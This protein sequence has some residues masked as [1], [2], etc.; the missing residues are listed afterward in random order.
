MA[1]R[2]DEIWVELD[3]K[4]NEARESRR[5]KRAGERAT[6]LATGKTG[7]HE[8]LSI[9][10]PGGWDNAGMPPERRGRLAYRRFG[11]WQGRPSG[12]TCGIDPNAIDP[13][14]A[15]GTESPKENLQTSH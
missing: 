7:V 8:Q 9:V 2:Q 3:S 11:R 15:C 5:R 10:S 4:L 6:D 12:A 1:A 13:S 14:G